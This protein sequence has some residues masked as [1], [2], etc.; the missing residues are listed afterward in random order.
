MPEHGDQVQLQ[1]PNEHEEN[2]QIIR[3]IRKDGADNPKIADPEIK[4]LGNAH[5]KE[6]RLEAN[7]LKFTAK[8]EKANKMF[9]KLDGEA[10]VEIQSDQ[11]IRIESKSDLMWDGR[12][13]NIRA[14]VGIYLACDTSSMILNGEVHG[15][16]SSAKIKGLVKSPGRTVESPAVTPKKKPENS[17]PVADQAQTGLD[18]NGSIPGV[19]SPTTKTGSGRDLNAGLDALGTIPFQSGGGLAK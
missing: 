14:G 2:A 3:A 11:I 10:G 4:Y 18:L 16:G 8:E 9:I 15:K 12:I 7:V 6:L 19:S 17:G 5:G 13:I 1:F